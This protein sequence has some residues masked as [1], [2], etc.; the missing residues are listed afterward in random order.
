MPATIAELLSEGREK[1]ADQAVAEL[2]ARLLLAHAMA[3]NVGFLYAWPE[4]AV[5]ETA[6][7]RFHDLVLRRQ[8]GEPIAHL[9]GS[10][11]FWSLELKVTP[12]TLIPRPET[13]R[14]VEL[15]LGLV[16]P[17]SDWSLL[18][19][20]TG[21]GAI[22]IAVARERPGCN[23]TATDISAAALK[24]ARENAA[25]HQVNNIQFVAGSW[26]TPVE[27]H[28]F[29]CI[30]SNPPYISDNDPSLARGD[31][32][33]EDRGALAAGE[34]GLDAIRHIINGARPQLETGGWLILEHGAEQRE[35]IHGLF[36]QAGFDD[37]ACHQDLAGLDR[38][39]CG[40]V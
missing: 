14:L 23:M 20:G 19:L 9:V 32:R 11:E 27:A 7:E 33:F 15:A 8:T 39:S 2:E 35:A 12:A 31:L 28:R 26:F 10:R 3:R 29:H 22:A 16:P 34:D 25:T 21:S 13:E 1:L 38:V 30:L 17:Y 6:A 4:R 24:I 18:E 36:D 40:R 37:I 5:S